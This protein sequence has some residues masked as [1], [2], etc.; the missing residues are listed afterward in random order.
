MIDYLKK[1]NKIQK[2]KEPVLEGFDD[3]PFDYVS[4]GMQN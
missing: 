1:S 2:T 3:G 4:I